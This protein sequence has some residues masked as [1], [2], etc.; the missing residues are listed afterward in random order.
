MEYSRKV[1][2][3]VA[4]VAAGAK[5]PAGT[6]GPAGIKGQAAAKG[7][8]GEESV[9]ATET[10]I[11]DFGSI[12]L[13]SP[14][15]GEG[16]DAS[17][18]AQSNAAGQPAGVNVAELVVSRGLGNVINHRD[19]EE[20]SNYYDALLAAEA[21]AKAGKKGCY[22]SKEPPVMHIQDLTMVRIN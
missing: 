9:G 10:R 1:V 5:G 22:S 16:D 21:R 14:I 3:E 20:R 15:K 4:P 7:P 12:F 17:A 13:L 2:V 6:K 19:F 11:I 18:V 8:A